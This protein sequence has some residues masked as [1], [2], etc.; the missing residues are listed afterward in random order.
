MIKDLFYVYGE[1]PRELKA[2]LMLFRKPRTRMAVFW[3]DSPRA[4]PDENNSFCVDRNTQMVI[5]RQGYG[6]DI[7]P[8]DPRL[9]SEVREAIKWFIKDIQDGGARSE[10]M[11][12]NTFYYAFVRLYIR[13]PSDPRS[14]SRLTKADIISVLNCISMLFFEPRNYGPREFTAEIR[15]VDTPG[16]T[17]SLGWITLAFVGDQPETVVH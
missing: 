5:P 16:S 12:E 11:D 10:L 14:D 2:E 17:R 15:R 13:P 1:P 3:S 6:R 4:W 9:A 8:N 7:D